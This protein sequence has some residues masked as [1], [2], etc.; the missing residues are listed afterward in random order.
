MP[1]RTAKKREIRVA[2]DVDVIMAANT[3]Q[4]LD[5]MQ[6]PSKV[7]NICHDGDGCIAVALASPEH[8]ATLL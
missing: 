2:P 3:D 1:I 6:R 7:A 5:V 4:S 8:G